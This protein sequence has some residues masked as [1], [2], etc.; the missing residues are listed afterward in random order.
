MASLLTI[1]QSPGLNWLIV[2]QKLLN[3]VNH[4]SMLAIPFFI[5]AGDIFSTGGVS[6]RLLYLANRL[7]GRFTGGLSMVATLAAAFF[8][9]ISG[10]SAATTAAIGGIMIPSM[11]KAGYARDYSAAVVAAS[12]LLGIIIPPSGTMLMYAVIAN[13]SILEMFTGGVI[14]GIIMALSLMAVEYFRAKKR[15]YGQSQFEIE[16]FKNKR[17]SS[18]I[19]ESFAALLSPVI[20]LGGIYAGVFTAT[21]AAGVAVL[22]GLLVSYFLYKQLRLKDL[23]KNCVSAGI[24]TSMIMFLIGSAAVFGWVLTVQQVPTKIVS[25][26]RAFTDSPYTV[27]LL[28]NLVLLVAGALL[29]NPAAITLLTPVL[30]PLVKSYG[31]DPT[32]FGLI[33]II[34]LA[35]GQI[36]PPIGMN[37]FV[38][39]NISGIKV[40]KI[41]VQVIPF[42]LVLVVDLFIFTYVP[43]LVT[44]LPSLMGKMPLRPY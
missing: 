1:L 29:D 30:V 2:T 22:Y 39:A 7:V 36:T 32:F 5:L 14:P 35:I 20:I 33:M 44:F 41:V 42:L 8:G 28:C 16:E 9:A 40:E 31:I 26:I 17:R 13:V 6:G 10:S 34:N 11:K 15:G 12:G 25:A 27:L 21:E 23:Y 18:I 38:A 43:Q 37:L 19:F 4:F 3:G 24:S